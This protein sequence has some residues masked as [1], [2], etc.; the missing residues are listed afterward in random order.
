M[1]DFG[2]DITGAV[3]GIVRRPGYALAIIA[4]L[5]VGIGANTAI[6]SVFNWILFRPLPAVARPSELVTIRFQTGKGSGSYFMPYL[7]YVELR[8]KVGAF[9]GTAASLPLDANLATAP[10]EDGIPGEIELVTSNYLAVLGVVPAPGRDF[11]ASEEHTVAGEPPVIISHQLWQRTF[12]AD[13][14]IIGR[15]LLI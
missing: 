3:R 6:F 11:L 8:D 15:S 2:R 9:A 14:A 4:T 10:G 1:R 5:A 12:Q 7:D 13:A